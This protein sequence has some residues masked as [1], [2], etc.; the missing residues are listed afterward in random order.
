MLLRNHVPYVGPHMKH[1]GTFFPVPKMADLAKNGWIGLNSISRERLAVQ[2]WL[3]TYCNRKT[4]FSISVSYNIYL[5]D[6]QNWLKSHFLWKMAE[7]GWIL[8][9]VN[10]WSYRSDRPLILTGKPTFLFVFRIIYTP[11]I[12]RNGWNNLLNFLKGNKGE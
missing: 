8:Y 1:P 3:T 7:F 11:Q 2:V 9:L 4:H 6:E 12:N 10:G 5:S